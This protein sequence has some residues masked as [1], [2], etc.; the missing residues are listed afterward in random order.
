MHACS[1]E[2]VSVLCCLVFLF[3]FVV[4]HACGV[5]TQALTMQPN[6]AQLYA[7]LMG[8][9]ALAV[10]GWVAWRKPVEYDVSVY[11]V[12]AIS[13]SSALDSDVSVVRLPPVQKKL[14]VDCTAT[15]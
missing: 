4:L 15:Q 5:V 2:S 8:F 1:V 3:F 7:V 12:P 13:Y 11:S 10:C 14:L 9:L 6:F